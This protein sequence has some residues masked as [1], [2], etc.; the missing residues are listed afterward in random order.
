MELDTGWR[1]KV[2]LPSWEI[3]HRRVK[4]GFLL[5]GS[6]MEDELLLLD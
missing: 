6:T 1:S 3:F 2:Y 5:M 4:L